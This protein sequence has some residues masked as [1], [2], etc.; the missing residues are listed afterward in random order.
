MHFDEAMER[1][2]KATGTRTQVELAGLLNIRQSSISD[3]KRRKSIPDNW[4]VALYEQYGLNPAWIKSGQGAAYLKEDP[5]RPAPLTML[6]PRPEPAAALEPT[7]SDMFEQIQERLGPGLRFIAFG[8]DDMVEIRPR[9]KR[10]VSMLGAFM[11]SVRADI[12]N[13]GA[14]EVGHVV[15]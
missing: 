8:G 2:K 11:E 7:V 14:E 3:A 4:L 1:I 12:R 6:A 5:D 13:E 9:V 10:P 15:G